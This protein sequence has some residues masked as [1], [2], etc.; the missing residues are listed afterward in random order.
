MMA[1]DPTK[2]SDA[3]LGKRLEWVR[4]RLQRREPDYRFKWDLYFERLEDL[5]KESRR[6]LDAG[7]GDNRTAHELSG[8]AICVGVD[9]DLTAP[10]GTAIR[11]SLEHL[12]FKDQTFDLVGCRYVVEHLSD[13]GA[14]WREVHRVMRPGGRLLIQTVNSRSLL[15]KMSR[16]LG[17]RIRRLISRVRYARCGADVFPVRD[18]F[19]TPGVFEHP[20]DGFRCVRVVMTQDIDT[21]SRLG[22][23]LSYL[24]LRWTRRRPDHRSTITAEWERI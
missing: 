11:A 5:A 21:Q 10:V 18:R 13:P 16:L 14:V 24:L 3:Y 4:R 2:Q 22:F 6:F 7:C 1:V 20:P 19:N 15:I 9:I 23:E 12:P 8:P 17:G